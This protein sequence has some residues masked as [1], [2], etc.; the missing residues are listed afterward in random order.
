MYILIDKS[1]KQFYVKSY[2]LGVFKVMENTDNIKDATKFENKEEIK[3]HFK[4]KEN[5][6]NNYNI[7]KERF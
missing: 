1:S 7:V 5:Y 4:D 6:L 3:R 2:Q